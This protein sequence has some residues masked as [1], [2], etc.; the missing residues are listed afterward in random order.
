MQRGL[1]WLQNRASLMNGDK[2]LISNV[3]CQRPWER[4]KAGLIS[5]RRLNV[6]NC[7]RAKKKLTRTTLKVSKQETNARI[8]RVSDVLHRY[9]YHYHYHSRV[10]PL[11]AP[12][13]LSLTRLLTALL[14]TAAGKPYFQV[15]QVNQQ[16]VVSWLPSASFSYPLRLFGF[17]RFRITTRFDFAAPNSVIS[18]L[19]LNYE[20]LFFK[21]QMK[22]VI[23]R[24][25]LA[26]LF[27]LEF[28]NITGNK[29]R[30]REIV[31]TII[32]TITQNYWK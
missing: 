20:L 12:F 13:P 26:E 30:Q 4:Q 29:I 15:D 17:L 27:S 32:K 18:W 11:F 6:L 14:S 19:T 7:K 10:C 28:P 31:Q 16:S 1:Q 25:R 21:K 3:E 5:S 8:I 22:N 24:Q 2:S 9:H 23:R